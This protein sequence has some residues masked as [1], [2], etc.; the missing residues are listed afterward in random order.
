MLTILCFRK[1]WFL[2]KINFLCK[3][4][5]L[6]IH[7][8]T[9][10]EIHHLKTK[11]PQKGNA[12]WCSKFTI[13]VCLQT[14]NVFLIHRAESLKFLSQY[15][16]QAD[17]RF[18]FDNALDVPGRRPNEPCLSIFWMV[19]RFQRVIPL[20]SQ[21]YIG[22]S[23]PHQYAHAYQF[24]WCDFISPLSES[25]DAK[26]V[27]EIFSYQGCIV[28]S[29]FITFT[30]GGVTGLFGDIFHSFPVTISQNES[31]YGGQFTLCQLS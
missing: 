4:K 7:P 27:L 15:S 10:F 16:S 13:F 21:I 23:E 14:H 26:N 29:F 24:F 31:L 17:Q 22:R 20:L 30:V 2:E 1:G 8:M 19:H 6:F 3:T 25:Q 5:L 18:P 28:M 12:W 11:K 9:I